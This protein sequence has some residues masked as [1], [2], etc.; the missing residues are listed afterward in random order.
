MSKYPW[1]FTSL[2]TAVAFHNA[3]DELK[4]LCKELDINYDSFGKAKH[5]EKAEGIVGLALF[6]NQISDL[7]EYCLTHRPRVQPFKFHETDWKGIVTMSDSAVR[8]GDPLFTYIGKK[9]IL[10]PDQGKYKLW[11]HELAE[12]LEK[13]Y[14]DDEFRQLCEHFKYNYLYIGH[15]DREEQA[16]ELV[17]YGIDFKLISKMIHYCKYTRPQVQPS[18]VHSIPWDDIDERAAEAVKSG[19]PLNDPLLAKRVHKA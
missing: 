10:V 13:Y 1:W 4:N 14:D 6:R 2:T 7:I 8:I 18:W 11:Y 12:A 9:R 15:L 3:D 16:S 5:E 19:N 17:A